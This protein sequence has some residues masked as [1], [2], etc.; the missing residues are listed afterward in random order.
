MTWILVVVFVHAEGV[1]SLQVEFSSP[2]RCE[3][4]AAEWRVKDQYQRIRQIVAKCHPR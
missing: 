4:A 1:H 2:S 3:Q